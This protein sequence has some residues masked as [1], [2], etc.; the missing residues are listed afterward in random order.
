MTTKELP[1]IQAAS[2]E[3][4]GA[5]CMHMRSPPSVVM[6]ENDQPVLRTSNGIDSDKDDYDWLMAAPEEARQIK[7]ARMDSDAPD[8]CP[9][10]WLDLETKRCRFYEFRPGICRDFELGSPECLAH[11]ASRGIDLTP[12][13]RTALLRIY[14]AGERGQNIVAHVY[15]DLERLGLA[16]EIR[17]NRWRCTYEGNRIADQLNQPQGT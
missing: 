2:C 16:E 6:W 10:C 15:R 12:R 9:C 17:P 5:C 3:N 11:R 13:Q 7:L 14:K 8:E 4:C 1:T